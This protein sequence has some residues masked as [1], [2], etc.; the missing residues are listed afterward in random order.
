MSRRDRRAA[1][2]RGKAEPAANPTE[3]A[4]RATLAFQEGRAIDA[5]VLCKQ[6]LALDARQPTALNIVGL[7]YQASG[8]HRL[9]VKTLAKAVAANELDAAC[10]YNLAASYQALGQR[11]D[12]ARY[13][14]KALALGLS[15]KGPEPFLLQDATIIQCLGRME[16]R[17]SLPVGKESVFGAG[18]IAAIAENTFLRCAL[19][20]TI[21]RGIPL[22]TFLTGLRQALLRLADYGSASGS[23]A[24][25]E[26][27]LGLFC[28]LAEQCFLNEYVFAQTAEETSRAEPLRALLQQKLSDGADV[29]VGL[30][31]AVGAYFPLHAIP[32][33]E[34]LLRSKWPD[35]AADLLRQQVK[36]P[37][38]EI[39][40][41]AAIPALTAV[42]NS[43]SV[44]VM[45]QYEENPYPRWTI[46]PLSVL[47][48]P[49]A[50][51]DRPHAGPSV[52]IAGCGTGEHPFDIAQKSP[53]ASVLAIDLSRVSLAYARRKT[54]EEGLRNIEYA[55]A[56]ILN[57]STL[58]RT[59]DRIE[60]VGVL[61]HLADPKAGWRVLLSLLAPN[62]I[63]RVGLYSD[64]ARRGIVEARA[65]VAERGYQPTA[66]GIRALRQ[67]IIR[68]KDEPRWKLLVQTIDFYST[69]GCRDMFFNVMEHRLT[70]PDIKSFL[71]E[72]GF[73]F[74][75][76]E[77]DA[78]VLEQFRQRNTAADALT[79][80]GAWAAFEAENP[81]TFLNMYVFSMCRKGASIATTS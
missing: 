25:P 14:R 36:E 10:Q 22:E 2:A 43:T 39:E 12:A 58:G 31:A 64:I 44:E 34:A 79:D 40:D 29:P 21:I 8:N 74:L 5:E 30:V 55:Q 15:G 19:G 66:E 51:A 41:R 65:I 67:T 59:F 72:Q 62:G 47:G 32:K 18:E 81:Q 3:L 46:N 71:D 75:G 63:M 54:R 4:A 77:L 53:E 61:H 35:Y 76:F 37:L 38:E 56:D 24:L 78:K 69:S 52:L 73:A 80:L 42:D 50:S 17:S 27:V 57:L 11:A 23:V 60:T 1:L 16:D 13:Y 68:E 9:A 6:I 28:A 7:L 45:R 49:K 48:R 70:I 33:A 26:D 20:S